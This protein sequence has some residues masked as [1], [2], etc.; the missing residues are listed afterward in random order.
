MDPT[1]IAGGQVVA[2]SNPVSPTSSVAVS[3][4][5]P[6]RNPLGGPFLGADHRVGAPERSAAQEACNCAAENR[7]TS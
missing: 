6:T 2:G 1:F 3:A 7:R 4:L 5:T